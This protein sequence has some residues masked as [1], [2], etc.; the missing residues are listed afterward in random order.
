MHGWVRCLTCT[1]HDTQQDCDSY[2]SCTTRAIDSAI[3]EAPTSTQLV[4]PRTFTPF[5]SEKLSNSRCLIH[6]FIH[7]FIHYNTLDFSLYQQISFCIPYFP[8][9]AFMNF[10]LALIRSPLQNNTTG[11]PT[12]PNPTNPNRLPAQC[13]PSALYRLL[14][15]SG[16][17]ALTRFSPKV[18]AAIAEPA[19]CAYESVM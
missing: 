7:S 15:A 18:I 11:A 13:A 19:N 14:V 17:K 4:F 5:S 6:S 12:S 16:K 3:R 1:S 10:D 8:S 2:S 9:P